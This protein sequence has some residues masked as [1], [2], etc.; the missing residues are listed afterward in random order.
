M[1]IMLPVMTMCHSTGFNLH[2]RCML[3]P[4]LTSSN[5]ASSL[6]ATDSGSHTAAMPC[7][8]LPLPS[9]NVWSRNSGQQSRGVA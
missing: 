8:M 1:M 6:A 2:G 3:A 4:L 5:A 7:V 9:C